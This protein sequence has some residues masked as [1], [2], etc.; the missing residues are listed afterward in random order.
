MEEKTLTTPPQKHDTPGARPGAVG[1][2]I[3]PRPPNSS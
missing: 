3:G 2:D 1:L